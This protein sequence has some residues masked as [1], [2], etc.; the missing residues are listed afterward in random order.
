MYKF[1]SKFK[2][3]KAYKTN[4]KNPTWNLHVSLRVGHPV[5][6]LHL[7]IPMAAEC[8]FC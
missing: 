6:R 2:S 4:W 3:N 8:I 7:T 5:L 1:T